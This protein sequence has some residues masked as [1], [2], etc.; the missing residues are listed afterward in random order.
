MTK[1]LGA[2]TF[3]GSA[4]VLT[5]CVAGTTVAGAQAPLAI[6]SARITI[7]GTSNIHAYTASTTTVRVTRA[8]VA[9]AQE[10]P[11]F[12]ASVLTP[13]VVQAFEI[14]IP[15]ATLTSPV[16]GIDKNMHAA[17]QVTGHPD[18]VFRL[19]RLEPSPGVAGALRGVGVLQIAGVD[20]E[21]SLDIKT[22]RKNATLN[23]QGRV[24]LL[25]TDFGIK[26]PTA[27]LGMLKT[28]PKVTVTFET[29]LAVP[30]S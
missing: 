15:A 28:D 5:M 23:V 24:R 20:R 7:S 3:L 27:M 29:V 1:R 13:G 8:Q 30:L 11:D 6:D 2:L 4:L 12:W 17:L 26:P 16:E 25:M 21:V 22:E 19:L 14:A 9:G 10:G 18:I